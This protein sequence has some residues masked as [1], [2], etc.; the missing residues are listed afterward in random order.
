MSRRRRSGVQRTG[1]AAR[2]PSTR[3][4]RGSSRRATW[5]GGRGGSI[6]RSAPIA[7]T[8]AR[9]SA[10]AQDVRPARSNAPA[11]ASEASHVV[12]ATSARAQGASAMPDANAIATGAAG[13]ASRDMAGVP[14]LRGG[15]DERTEPVDL[16][17]A[18]S[19]DALQIVNRRERAHGL[20][21]RDDPRGQRAA[22]PGQPRELGRVRTIEIDERL[23]RRLA[24]GRTRDRCRWCER[25]RGPWG[26]LELLEAVREVRVSAPPVTDG[27]PEPRGAEKDEQH[28][29][30]VACV[31]RH[32]P[33]I[34]RGRARD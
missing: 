4:I 29:Q 12:Q 23:A 1:S 6:P 25:A 28:D 10:A 5:S 32:G 33:T 27:Q 16:V 21:R 20:A 7:P 24:L 19:P 14:S 31:A 17:P 22:D 8:P 15:G 26:P 2:R 18:E 34:P 3:A 9:S 30:L 13:I 11:L